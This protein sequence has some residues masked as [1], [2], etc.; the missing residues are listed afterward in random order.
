MSDTSGKT[1]NWI[2]AFFGVLMILFSLPCVGLG[3]QEL[4]LDFGVG[5]LFFAIAAIIATPGIFLLLLARRKPPLLTIDESLE[6][7]VLSLA[8]QQQGELTASRL[9]MGTRLSLAQAQTA[10]EH[11][12]NQRLAIST[13]GEG[14]TQIFHFP[15]FQTTLSEGEDFMRR[16]SDPSLDV[17]ARSVVH[18]HEVEES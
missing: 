7:T 3:F 14:G 12:E 11:F 4:F 10:L 15:E 9:A 5:I 2:M 6:R 1:R 18:S 8:M 16:L 13:I 17:D